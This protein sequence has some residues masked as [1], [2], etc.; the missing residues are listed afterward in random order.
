VRLF[1]RLER[2]ESIEIKWRA[3]QL[4]I[5]KDPHR[6]CQDFPNQAMLKMPQIVHPQAGDGK[7]LRQ[8][9]APGFYSLPQAGAGLEQSRTRG[10]VILLRGAV[11]TKTPCRSASTA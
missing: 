10:V 2:N 9:R 6:M 4:Q 1:V 11:T 7:A 3:S 5:E 8:M